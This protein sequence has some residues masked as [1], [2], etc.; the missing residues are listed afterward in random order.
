[1]GPSAAYTAPPGLGPANK[2]GQERSSS[3]QSRHAGGGLP[4]IVHYFSRRWKSQRQM[5]VSKPYVTDTCR[6]HEYL[7][8]TAETEASHLAPHAAQLRVEV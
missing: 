2:V 3:A 8:L 1:M 7:S 4:E 5:T 6:R